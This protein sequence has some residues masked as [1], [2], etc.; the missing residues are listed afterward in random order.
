MYRE[1]K[2]SDSFE[3]LFFYTDY[4]YKIYWTP[5]FYKS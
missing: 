3:S 2:K 4:E 1:Y 5:N